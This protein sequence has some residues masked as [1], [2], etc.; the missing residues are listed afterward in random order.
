MVKTQVTNGHFVNKIMV[1]ST[2][3]M[4]TL[5]ALW[6]P[7]HLYII[8]N[9]MSTW[10]TSM[11]TRW[12]WINKQ[13]NPENSLLNTDIA[14]N[15]TGFLPTIS[16]CYI[17]SQTFA[18]FPNYSDKW[19]PWKQNPRFICVFAI[20]QWPRKVETQLALLDCVPTAWCPLRDVQRS[21]NALGR[22]WICPTCTPETAPVHSP[23]IHTC[24]HVKFHFKCFLKQQSSQLLTVTIWVYI[25][26]IY[27]TEK[28]HD[29]WMFNDGFV[30]TTTTTTT[31]V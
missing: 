23:T 1:S 19:S 30:I 26:Q 31:T 17:N 24:F 12:Q 25:L 8:V 14:P 28:Y 16:W 7:W 2:N 10:K 11:Q 5:Q 4:T 27:T 29:F 21:C 15:L 20:V 13:K 18:G 3:R 9:A 6:I 22:N